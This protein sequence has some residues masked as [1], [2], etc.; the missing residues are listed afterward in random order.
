PTRLITRA[1][2][3]AADRAL[4]AWSAVRRSCL[5]DG[6][7]G[8]LRVLEGPGGE[9]APV[10]P[11]SQVLAAATDLALLSGDYDDAERLVRGLRDYQRGDG[12]P[13]KPGRRRRYYD[14]NAWIG[15]CFAQLHLQTGDER[16]LRRARR[17]LA[18]VRE[19]QRPEGGVRWVEGRRSL[20]T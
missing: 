7:N 6:P 9:L 1:M 3:D 19:G 11:V 5:V 4:E 15:L 17:V 10:W 12:Y 20:N 13:P 2:A 14:D 18:F 8:S 16:W